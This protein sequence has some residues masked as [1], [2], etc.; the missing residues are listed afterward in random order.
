MTMFDD[1]EKAFEAKFAH[2]EETSFKIEMRA[3][4][5]LALWAADTLKLAHT[6]VSQYIE[7]MQDIDIRQRGMN[8]VFDAIAAD[9]RQQGTDMSTNEISVMYSDCEDQARRQI[10]GH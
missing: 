9:L 7:R 10:M 6:D 3:C 5:L 1:R 4:K 8:A 2:D